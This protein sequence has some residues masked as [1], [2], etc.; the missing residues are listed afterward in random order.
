MDAAR[1]N[2]SHGSLD[3]ALAIHLLVRRIADEEGRAI[4]TLAD[5]PGPKIRAAN[6]GRE[7]VEFSEG[8]PG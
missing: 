5:L 4:G 2:L 6:F 8:H 1:I 7:V 3:D